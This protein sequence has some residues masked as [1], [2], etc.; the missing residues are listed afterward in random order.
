[1]LNGK[2][3]ES[4]HTDASAEME[5]M[6]R[7]VITKSLFRKSNNTFFNDYFSRPTQK[8]ESITAWLASCLIGLDSA[9]L[10]VLQSKQFYLFGQIQS[11]QTGG[12]QFS[13]TSTYGTT[14]PY[15]VFN[16]QSDYLKHCSLISCGKCS[17]L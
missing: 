9:A 7:N 10:L 2:K 3:I 14:L 16:N 1:M 12:Q 5:S 13:D 8:R 4:G 15:A 17:L 11:S 6:Q